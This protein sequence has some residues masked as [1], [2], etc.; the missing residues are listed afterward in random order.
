MPT[1]AGTVPD[2]D[3]IPF[4]KRFLSS[5]QSGRKDKQ[6]SSYFDVEAFVKK[7][8][9]ETAHL[10]FAELD[11]A[12]LR[13]GAGYGVDHDE[14]RAELPDYVHPCRELSGV[15]R[16]EAGALEKHGL[17]DDLLI[18]TA[19]GEPFIS[20]FGIYIDRIADMG[21]RKQLLKVLIP[22]QMELDGTAEIYESEEP[23]NEMEM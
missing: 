11:E 2:S 19:D 21:Y 20:T 4:S 16:V 9:H 12:L 22:M 6:L 13:G 7:R 17:Y 10:L 1:A 8:L 3:R 5:P 23:T 14:P 18:T 15:G